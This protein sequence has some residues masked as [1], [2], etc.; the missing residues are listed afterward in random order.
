MS[1]AGKDGIRDLESRL[2]RQSIVPDEVIATT[3]VS[4]ATDVATQV[5]VARK[6]LNGW[7]KN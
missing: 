4:A 1:T 5:F 3:R 7:T 6:D 2:S